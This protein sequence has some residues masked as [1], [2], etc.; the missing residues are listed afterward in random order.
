MDAFLV[1]AHNI[2]NSVYN[3]YETYGWLAYK[4]EYIEKSEEEKHTH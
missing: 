3:N 4:F 2:F 1:K